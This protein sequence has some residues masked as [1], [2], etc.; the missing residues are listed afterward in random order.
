[1]KNPDR[2]SEKLLLIILILFLNNYHNKCFART[3]VLIRELN[4]SPIDFKRIIEKNKTYISY[5]DYI[6][7]ERGA[8][9]PDQLQLLL[10]GLSKSKSE[11]PQTI[12][13]SFEYSRAHLLDRVTDGFLGP[14]RRHLLIRLITKEKFNLHT[15]L[16]LNDLQLKT[17][18]EGVLQNPGSLNSPKFNFLDDDQLYINGFEIKKGLFSQVLVHPEIF[19]HIAYI[20]QV[21]PPQFLWIKG[22]SFSNMSIFPLEQTPLLSGNCLDP[23]VNN[24][25]IDEI[26]IPTSG[27]FANSCLRD[28]SRFTKR[29]SQ[30]ELENLNS[31]QLATEP[32]PSQFNDSIKNKDTFWKIGGSVLLLGVLFNQLYQNKELI[33]STTL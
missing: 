21:Y 19:Y 7:Y 13:D 5:G 33:F 24:S 6:K 25:Q 8:I 32:F 28:L 12:N 26:S 20:S 9:N 14:F 30:Y 11:N 4:A 29:N 10:E 1:M 23:N 15:S 16:P 22:K 31:I 18:K 17:L 2:F 27:L 3:N